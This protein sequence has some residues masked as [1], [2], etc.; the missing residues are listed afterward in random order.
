MGVHRKNA[1]SSL[2]GHPWIKANRPGTQVPNERFVQNNPSM[3]GLTNPP[4]PENQFI[5]LQIQYDKEKKEK[6]L[7]APEINEFM[8]DELCYAWWVDGSL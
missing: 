4:P 5:F 2:N 8:I 1:W 6:K 3:C 7:G